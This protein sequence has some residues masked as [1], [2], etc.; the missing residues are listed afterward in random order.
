MLILFYTNQHKVV[1]AGGGGHDDDD[2]HIVW[3]AGYWT[4]VSVFA[5]G[6]L[7]EEP[8]DKME[9]LGGIA[10]E[11]VP[12]LSPHRWTVQIT[13]TDDGPEQAN[14]EWYSI[15]WSN[16]GTRQDNR[17]KPVEWKGRGANVERF[18][19]V[20]NDLAIEHFSAHHFTG[21]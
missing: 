10:V 3:L 18:F 2:N 15:W 21:P 19:L 11:R 20:G 13:S 12:N 16:L 8:P 17:I 1:V 7:E 5:H 14:I 6:L 4:C 9:E